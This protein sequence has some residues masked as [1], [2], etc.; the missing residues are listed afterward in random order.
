MGGCSVF[1]LNLFAIE[2]QEEEEQAASFCA[3]GHAQV[4]R[5]SMQHPQSLGNNF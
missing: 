3:I 5:T 4:E 1:S 2:K